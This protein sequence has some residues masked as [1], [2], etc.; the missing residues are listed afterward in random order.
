MYR[1]DAWVNAK[2]MRAQ[3]MSYVDIGKA[4]GVDR[5]TA[6]KLCMMEELP[7]PKARERSSIIDPFSEVIDA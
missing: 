1:K 3:G 5:R 7:E 6:K 2:A 4:L